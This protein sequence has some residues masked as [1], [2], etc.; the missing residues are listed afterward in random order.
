M[1]YYERG[2][3]MN[4]IIVSILIGVV[5]I[6]VGI[7]GSGILGNSKLKSSSDAPAIVLKSVNGVDY[8]LSKMKGE[9]VYIKFWASWCSICLAG[10]EETD[11]LSAQENGF[12]V[13]TIVSPNY[14]GEQNATDFKAWYKSLDMKNMIVLIDE[15]GA[16]A[17]QYG[18]RAYPT[19]VFISADGHLAKTVPG[20]LSN[21]QIIEVFNSDDL[22]SAAE[23]PQT[24]AA[25][26]ATDY[27]AA[28]KTTKTVEKDGLPKNPNVSLVFDKSKLKDIYLAGG[29]FWGLEAYMAR[30]YGVYDVTSGYA[31]GK[32]ENSVYED[33]LY[34]NSGHA[35]TVHVVYDPDRVSLNQLLGYYFRVIDPT[36]IN[37]QGND[38]GDQYRTGVY[39]TD[40]SELQIIKA[41]IE[42]KQKLF[43]KT[44][45]VEVEPLKQYTLAEEYHQDY[46][47]KNPNGYCHINLYD[48]EQIL[49]DPLKYPKPSD[50][51]LKKQLTAIQYEVTQ[52]NHTE[53]AFSNEYWDFF[54]KGIYVDVVTGEPM[55]S[56]A[57]KYD[58]QC[59]WPSFTKPISPEV[60]TYKV[61]K[62]YNMTRTE[63]RS[64]SGN[65]HLG[66]VFDDGP[67]DKGGKRYCINSVSIKFIP[68]AEMEKQGYS[69][70]ISIIQ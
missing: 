42:T 57:D 3:Y 63:V 26:A 40:P 70:L 27:A 69:Y 33:L 52:L 66:H 44:I 38:V 15:D 62:S 16:V 46:L 12:K 61:D 68:L 23:N 5:I 30:V 1:N 18:V 64:R 31:N 25:V 65:T 20:H 11:A 36:S 22:K 43:K 54:E 8:D 53:E 17:K 28:G 60:V 59:G 58:S 2:L 32:T 51:V 24:E 21:E 35:E 45:A 41:F 39:Y 49:I 19:S 9:Q 29:C 14:N 6:G 10:L 48:V 67:V 34:N 50:E 7:L 37:K 56:S 55:F 13:I 4:K 47:E